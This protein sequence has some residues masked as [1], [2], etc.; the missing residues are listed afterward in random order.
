MCQAQGSQASK[1]VIAVPAQCAHEDRSWHNAECLG[2]DWGGLGKPMTTTTSQRLGATRA[3]PDSTQDELLS[4]PWAALVVRRRRR[5]HPTKDHGNVE[6]VRN[7][8]GSA[9]KP[10]RKHA[11]A[12]YPSRMRPETV[13]TAQ[14]V[15]RGLL[16]FNTTCIL[17]SPGCRAVELSR[18]TRAAL[19]RERRGGV[20]PVSSIWTVASHAQLV[21][22]PVIPTARQ[23]VHSDRGPR[24]WGS[25]ENA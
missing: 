19:T 7:W 11:I 2:T 15:S 21:G 16:L 23:A 20:T 14:H 12:N 22:F 10:E 8:C 9:S 1:P 6:L 18:N 24:D 3:P 25:G 13:C 17:L 4:A 5:Y